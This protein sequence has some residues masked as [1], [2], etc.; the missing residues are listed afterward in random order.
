MA[1]KEQVTNN[2]IFHLLANIRWF[3]GFCR[4]SLAVVWRGCPADFWRGEKVRVSITEF[5]RE[6]I[7]SWMVR[8]SFLLLVMIAI[9]VIP[10]NGL[11][12]NSTVFAVI[13]D[14]GS[15]TQAEADVAALVKS[16]NP[17]FI[18]TVG[19]NNY[20]DGAA[21]TIDRNIGKYYHDF[22]F[23]YRGSYGNGA[24]SNKFFPSLGNH[25]WHAP[26]AQP[27]LDYFTLPGN[28]RYYDFIKGSIHF[29]IIDSVS[30]E[31]DG[32]SSTSQQATWLRNA[33]AAST[34][35]FDIVILH[36]PPYSSGSNHGSNKTLQWPYKD[37]GADAVL[38]G[39]EH[40]YERLIVDGTL[41]IVNGAGGKSLYPF[42][43]PIQ[44]SQVRYNSDY[45]AMRVEGFD[46]NIQFQFM[47]RTGQL[48][49]TY[50]LTDSAP[51]RITTG[52]FRPS[53]GALYLKNSNT[54]GYAD[55]A[56][57]YGIKGD[58]PV[59]GDWDG[60]GTDTIGVYRN[61]T[62]YLRN[63]NT[64]G[65][66]DMMF[67]FG[68]P[69]DQP[70]AG[71]WNG[72]G[73]DTIGVYRRSNSTFYLRNS[74]TSGAPEMSFSLGVP[75][76]VGIAGDWNGDGL[77]TTGVFR[78]SNGVLYLKN[79][80]ETGFADLALNYGQA[81]DKPVTGDWN[82]DGIDTIGVYRNGTFFL[83]NS[84]TI[85]F[86]DI[87]FALGLPGDIPIAGDWDGLP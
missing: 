65:F 81:G 53:N 37:W 40:N 39:H 20:P 57:N 87:V 48:I 3:F 43:T 1:K 22:I 71:D 54:S 2:T 35:K 17:D 69:G 77:V 16:W 56:I 73:I 25:D 78:P 80:N 18:V 67:A 86:A 74:N 42:G 50:T 55:V 58:Y 61:G 41:Y 19:D 15:D 46:N 4:D 10:A 51:E 21:S 72:N 45:G 13:G 38:A 28:E 7:R 52:V 63:S 31:P 68:A 27:Y 83:R 64:I 75:G 60:N 84:N 26:N 82:D 59:T 32:T 30:S 70:V 5:P 49:D 44:G 62:F 12:P 6:A 47:T 33:L 24:T 79:T 66:A 85:G 34:A 8:G 14:Y 11:E 9:G 36:Y 23:P 29:F 76:D